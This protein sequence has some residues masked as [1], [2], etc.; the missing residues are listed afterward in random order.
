MS[1]AG[2]AGYQVVAISLP[3]TP[4]RHCLGHDWV[5]SHGARP[6]CEG[7][8]VRGWIVHDQKVQE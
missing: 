8:T 4:G 2:A 6:V 1:G 5:G 7:L 3:G